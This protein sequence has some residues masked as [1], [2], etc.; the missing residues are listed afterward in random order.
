MKCKAGD[1]AHIIF[2]INPANT[3]RIVKV[4]EYIGRFEQAEQFQMHGMDCHCPVTDH[5]WWIEADDLTIRFGPS[6]KAYIA[7]TWLQPIKNPDEELKEEASK[8]LDMFF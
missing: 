8:A 4:V 3:G 2:S 1:L 6:P 7:D 5:Y